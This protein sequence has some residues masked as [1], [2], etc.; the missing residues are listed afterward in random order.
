MPIRIALALAF[1]AGTAAACPR[2]AIVPPDVPLG[3]CPTV[4]L[5]ACTAHCMPTM[6]HLVLDHGGLLAT[7]RGDAPYI[8]EVRGSGEPSQWVAVLRAIAGVATAER[9]GPPGTDGWASFKVIAHPGRPDLREAI[10]TAASKGG[11]TIREPRREL[12][13]LERLFLE[14]I[15]ADGEGRAA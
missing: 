11:L 12:L 9:D 14:M 5:G 7:A 8:V 4:R 13:G 1:V 3:G 10:A 6:T 15:E 2:P